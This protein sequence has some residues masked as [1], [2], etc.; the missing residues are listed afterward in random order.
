M[1]GA[2]ALAPGSVRTQRRPCATGAPSPDRLS[3]NARRR[4][5]TVLVVA[6][7]VLALLGGPLLYARGNIFDSGNFA[8]N[9]SSAL[10]SSHARDAVSRQI[11]RLTLEQAPVP[12]AASR[13]LMES[14]VGAALETAPFKSLLRAAAIQAHR[15]AFQRGRGTVAFTLADAGVA[16]IGAL[17]A[18]A[19]AIAKQIPP[20][21]SPQLAKFTN[22]GLGFDFVEVGY[23]ARLLGILL[24]LAA[25]LC[26]AGALGISLERRR[27]AGRIGIALAVDAVLLYV[28]LRIAREIAIDQV[29]DP[30]L[31]PVAG[32]VWDAFFGS[33]QTLTLL[34][35]A[36]GVTLFAAA[37]SLLERDQ[38]AGLGRRGAA[39]V[40]ASPQR[41]ALRAA[42]AV[43]ILAVGVGVVAEPDLAIQLL[44]VA[45]GAVAIFYATTELLE[46]A[47]PGR[48]RAGV[49]EGAR[50]A[51]A[52]AK[53]LWPGG[54][55]AALAGALVG[56]LVAAVV[57]ALAIPGSGRHR[58][59]IPI[60]TCNGF[61]VLCDRPLNLVAFAAAHNAMSADSDSFINANQPRGMVPQLQYGIRAFLIDDYYGVPKSGFVRTVLDKKHIPRPE[62]ERRAG[63]PAV[64]ALEHLTR[65]AGF[66]PPNSP[67][68][69]I[70]L[71]HVFCEAGYVDMTKTLTDVRRWMDD[72]PNEVLIFFIEDTVT[73][74]DAAK[75]FAK[76]G[77]TRYLYVHNREDP[78]PTLRTMIAT[79][80][81]LFVLSENFKAS[82]IPWYHNGFELSQETPY[83]FASPRDFSCRPNRGTPNS[84]L[85][86]VNHWIDTGK[87]SPGEAKHVN[88]FDYLLLRAR[89]CQRERGLLPN[90]VAVDWYD[91]GDLLGVVNVLNDLPRTARLVSP[92]S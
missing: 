73:P 22:K 50:G 89:Q 82:G 5:A 20:H 11:V 58:R 13:P 85:F 19:P 66:P 76:A 42:R 34:T 71:C 87:P 32:A 56:A 64:D 91:R 79:G 6:G 9:A 55:R 28:V 37:S 67:D 45:V 77:L 90:M 61:A 39:A 38:L 86:L 72:H 33:L 80:Q 4:A 14:V 12:V 41:P 44:V 31:D 25:L 88:R 83:H 54:R 15:A 29:P 70:Y 57:V 59:R 75:V 8:A 16:I 43:G 63:K 46:L 23:H 24:P 60:T 3:M 81:R 1:L 92:T 17:K 51:A 2:G 52:R 69:H 7:A 53:G 30:Q 21:I 68:K 78:W 36:L 18:V 62:L 35:G 74:Q 27:L 48:E 49:R 65:G 10:E 40:L 84:P 47:G 26:W